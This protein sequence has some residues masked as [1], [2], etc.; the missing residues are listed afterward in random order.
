M[1]C[2]SMCSF[3]WYMCSFHVFSMWV[4]CVCA[5]FHMCVWAM[6]QKSYFALSLKS[7]VIPLSAAPSVMAVLIMHHC[8]VIL[9]SRLTYFWIRHLMVN[10]YISWQDGGLWVS[11]R[12]ILLSAL[13][14]A[15]WETRRGSPIV[16]HL[17]SVLLLIT[18]LKKYKYIN[19]WKSKKIFFKCC[20]KIIKNIHNNKSKELQF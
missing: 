4:G 5:Y 15:C 10:I 20:L 13:C 12:M 17:R 11:G 16:L 19:I 2:V 9:R 7:R 8:Y 6:V 18:E 3:A 14:I 1:F